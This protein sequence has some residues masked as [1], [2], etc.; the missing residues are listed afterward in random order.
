M[1]SAAVGILLAMLAVGHPQSQDRQS[2]DLQQTPPRQDLEWP[3]PWISD[4]PMVDLSGTWRFDPRGSDPMLEAWKGREILYHIRQGSGLVVLEF[5][6]EGGRSNR[7]VYRWDGSVSR[8][9]RG[10]DSVAERARWTDGGQVLEVAGRRWPNEDVE[11][12][13]A[14]RFTYSVQSGRLTFVQ[15]NGSG[16]TTWYFERADGFREGDRD[17]DD[18]VTD[19]R[20]PDDRDPDDRLRRAPAH[21]AETS[22]PRGAR[23]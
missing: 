5:V 13:Q 16:T 19:D 15:H 17:A 3:V 10:E 1:T 23:A 4:V 14:Y 20:D 8:F 22:C 11:A 6:P 7:Q 21:P 2:Q 9:E 18:R 12:V